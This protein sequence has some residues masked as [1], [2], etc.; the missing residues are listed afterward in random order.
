MFGGIQNWEKGF[1]VTEVIR[2][3]WNIQIMVDNVFKFERIYR[4]KRVSVMS[5]GKDGMKSEYNNNQTS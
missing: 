5:P 2:S 3:K 1:Q 4:R